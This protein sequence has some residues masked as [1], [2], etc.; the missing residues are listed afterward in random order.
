MGFLNAGRL[1]AQVV[2][3]QAVLSTLVYGG[4]AV[5]ILRHVGLHTPDAQERM[6]HFWGAVH[7][8]ALVSIGWYFITFVNRVFWFRRTLALSGDSF[9]VGQVLFVGTGLLIFASILSRAS[10]G[11]TNVGGHTASNPP[12]SGL[13]AAGMIVFLIF[14]V[15]AVFGRFFGS[16]LAAFAATRSHVTLK[17]INTTARA[18][19][20]QYLGVE[21][22]HGL[23]RHTT[24]VLVLLVLLGPP[25]LLLIVGF[26]GR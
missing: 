9:P 11:G 19:A 16:F 5:Y 18:G 23:F 2:R 15:F 4:S 6:L 13:E 25:L 20:L 8:A 24:A 3:Y 7:M 1:S 17:S 26:F 12:T 22:K 14:L 21:D 10:Y